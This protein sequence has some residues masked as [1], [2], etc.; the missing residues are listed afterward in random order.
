MCVCARVCGRGRRRQPGRAPGSGL[1]K[2]WGEIA[3]RRG[4]SVTASTCTVR[5]HRDVTSITH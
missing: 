2:W 1:S 3:G 5:D 4:V